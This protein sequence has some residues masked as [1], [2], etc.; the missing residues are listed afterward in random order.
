MNYARSLFKNGK[1]RNCLEL[2][3]L[4]Y[5][6]HSLF[7][8]I[9]YHYGRLCVKSKDPLFLGSA[10]G[11]LQECLKSCSETRHGQIYFWLAFAYL[12]AEEKL[13]AFN[14]AK[15]FASLL[16][17]ALD[18]LNCDP[19]YA[20]RLTKKINQIQEIIK[21][22]HIHVLSIEMLENALED[23]PLKIDECK[24]HCLSIH[25]FDDLEGFLYEARMY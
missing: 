16:T 5:T 18:K 24:A 25:E 23:S 22:L 9:L 20:R 7:T 10:I 15:K 12:Q 6:K 13:E 1:L 19:H 2:L 14:C 3:Q 17:S 11:A 21:S 8:V 4:E